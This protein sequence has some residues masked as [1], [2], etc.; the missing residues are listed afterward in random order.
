MTPGRM[1]RASGMPAA[2]AMKLADA[3]AFDGGASAAFA[4]ALG[5]C[6]APGGRVGLAH[7]VVAVNHRHPLPPE[8][9]L[10]KQ[11]G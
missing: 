1:R 5:L 8:L 10:P 2:R 6:G 4:C 11:K 9:A 7:G 3:P